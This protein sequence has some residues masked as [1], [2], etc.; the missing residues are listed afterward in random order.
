MGKSDGKVCF[1]FMRR[2][3]KNTICHFREMLLPFSLFMTGA[4]GEEGEI[5]GPMKRSSV[6]R[7]WKLNHM[8]LRVGFEVRKT[9]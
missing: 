3:N 7:M 2:K 9:H 6:F 4:L 1:V 8:L 5:E